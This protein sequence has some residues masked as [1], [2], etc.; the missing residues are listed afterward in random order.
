MGT[1]HIYLVARKFGAQSLQYLLG[2]LVIDLPHHEEVTGQSQNGQQQKPDHTM[3]PD[4]ISAATNQFVG[5][6]RLVFWY[7]LRQP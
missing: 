6:L 4:A 1:I 5:I 7:Y 3:F 2:Q